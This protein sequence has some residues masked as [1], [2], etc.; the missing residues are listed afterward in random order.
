M[1]SEPEESSSVKTLA[2]GAFFVL[3]GLI[4]SKLLWYLYRVIIARY[5]GPEEYGLFSL[6]FSI[7]MTAML[8]S[9]VGI[10][11]GV[12]RFISKYIGKDSESKIRGTIFSALEITLPLSLLVAVSLFYSAPFI[13]D[14]IGE[15]ELTPVIYIFAVAIPFRTFLKDILETFRA[16]KRMDYFAG[17]ENILQPFMMLMLTIILIYNGYGVLG[18]T[19]AYTLSVVS[20]GILGFYILQSKLLPVLGGYKKT[21]NRRELFIYS[22]PLFIVGIGH[23][24]SMNIDN[25]MLGWFPNVATSDIGVYNS[26]L[27]TAYLV[28]SVSTVFAFILFPLISTHLAKGEDI[29]VSKLISIAVRWTLVLALPL[30]LLLV[31]FSEPILA[32]LFGTVYADGNTVLSIVALGILL[33]SV[34]TPIE[35]Y[36]LARDKTN[37]MMFNSLAT[38]ATNIGLNY[39]FIPIYGILGAGIAIALSLVVLSALILIEAILL[40]KISLSLSSIWKPVFSAILSLL[41]IYIIR[42]LEITAPAVAEAGLFLIIYTNVFVAVKGFNSE[43]LIIIEIAEKHLDMDLTILKNLVENMSAN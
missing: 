15:P 36:L 7:F 16:F 20:A 29:M 4:A 9:K 14:L 6:G 38:V 33:K 34:I 1:G 37:W 3:A 40:L 41:S 27:P 32:T 42:Y 21:Q 8:F 26:A 24:L 2:M 5:L 19:V 13:A 43:D 17:I 22:F 23:T 28:S 31:L 12:T 35:K 39:I 11:T 18:V 25:F 30:A 10:P